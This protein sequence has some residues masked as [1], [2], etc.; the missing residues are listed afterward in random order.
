[1]GQDSLGMER[2]SGYKALTDVALTF[3][4]FFLSKCS[5]ETVILWK[6]KCSRL[7]YF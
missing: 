5:R 6:C 3:F 4:F 7:T 2:I 1:M